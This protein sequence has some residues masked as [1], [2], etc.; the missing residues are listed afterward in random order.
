MTKPPAPSILVVC[1]GNICRSPMAAG[2]LRAELGSSSF[3]LRVESAG[4]GP[5]HVGKPP[6]PRAIATAQRRGID[7]T[8]ERARM[9]CEQDYVTFDF[10]LA[11]DRSVLADVVQR[12]P[13]EATAEIGL[14]CSVA[15]GIEADIADP[16]YGEDDGF[17][18]CFDEIQA[19][20]RA[21]VR[22]L[23]APAPD[24]AAS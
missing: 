12:A 22:R 16:Y 14:F 8:G 20:A 23:Q 6:D 17:E 3:D 2:I 10:I 24:R 7:L 19:T 18:T 11:M 1:L 21:L 5:W 9:I 4:V 13:A 15:E